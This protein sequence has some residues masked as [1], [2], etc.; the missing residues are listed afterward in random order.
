[1][2]THGVCTAILTF[3]LAVLPVLVPAHH[4]EA[5]FQGGLEK[6]ILVTVVGESNLPV[7]DLTAADFSIREDDA[8]RPVTSA[9]LA[10]DTLFIAILV[11]TSKPMAGV[12][13][14]TQQLRRS[15]SAFLDV[16]ATAGPPAEIALYE[17]GGVALK[18][19]D[20]TRSP[21]TLNVAIRA[22][23]AKQPIERRALRSARRREPEPQRE[24]Q[25]ATGDRVHQ[26]QRTGIE[27]HPSE[28]R[29]GRSPEVRRHRLGDFHSR[30][31]D[32]IGRPGRK[33]GHGQHDGAQAGRSAE[34]ND[35][36]DRRHAPQSARCF[37]PRDTPHDGRERPALAVRRDLHPTHGRDGP[38]N[39]P[40]AETRWQGADVVLGAVTAERSSQERCR[41][42]RYTRYVRSEEPDSCHL[43]NEDGQRQARSAH[44]PYPRTRRTE[45]DR[46]LTTKKRAP[47]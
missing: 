32:R 11:D 30:V 22:P 20:F 23:G 28:Q 9:K 1:M 3:A 4:L 46:V 44:P 27:R 15:L 16:I 42:G 6:S 17:F 47:S 7:T 24:A 38:A 45:G 31:G 29:A 13:P 5:T 19:A 33:T 8:Q 2:R 10:T 39:P 21:A 18:T 43:L 36:V 35:P 25:P 37:I 12:L 40:G 26:L 34:R 41:D 14:P